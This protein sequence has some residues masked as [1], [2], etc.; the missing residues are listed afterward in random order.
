MDLALRIFLILS[1]CAYFVILMSML[2]KGKF[3][4]KYALIW[5]FMGIAMIVFII[6]PNAVYSASRLIGGS[7]P[8]NAVF[9]V[10]ALFSI[11]MLISV[12]SVNSQ[13]SEK[14]L[15]LSQNLALLEERVRRLEEES[16]K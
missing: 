14:N 15:R 12:T 7:N 6:W 13:L 5:L 10:F 1:T 16:K 8:V 3:G 11:I 2:K 9:L 4:L